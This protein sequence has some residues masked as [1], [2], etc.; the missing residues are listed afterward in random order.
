MRKIA[1]PMIN[2]VITL[3]YLGL[4]G[5]GCSVQDQISV[6]IDGKPKA[7]NIPAEWAEGARKDQDAST[8]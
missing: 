6:L 1:V 7:L 8:L 2:R 4:A 5:L 3:L